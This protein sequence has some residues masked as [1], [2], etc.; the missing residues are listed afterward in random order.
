MHTAKSSVLLVAMPYA[1]VTIPS[2]QLPVLEAYCRQHGIDV[3]TRHLY[4]KA[5]EIYGL[6]NYHSL[7]H[8]PGD[9]YT[10][11]VAFSQYLFPDHWEKN[12]EKI[13]EHYSTHISA[14]AFSFEDYLRLTDDF[15]HWTLDH[16]YWQ[17]FDLI[18][19]TLNYGQL[20]PS[21][22]IAKHIKQHNPEKKIVLGGSRVVGD[23]G[24]G[25]LRAF[26]YI[27][28]VVSGDG[29]DPLVRLASDPE[30]IASIP[31]LIY[32]E[33]DNVRWNAAEPN[34]DFTT[35][36]LPSYDPF[37][38]T[39][40][41][42]SSELQQFYHYHGRLPVEISR[43]CWW[44]RCTFCNLNIQHPCYRE[45]PIDH[46]TSEIQQFS[47]RYHVLDFQLIGNTLP[48]T[49][50]R[51]L[52]DALEHLSKDFSFFVEARAGQLTSDDYRR[53]KDAGFTT[54]QTGIESFSRH[55]LRTMNKGVRVIDNIAALKFCRQYDIRNSYNLIIHYPNEAPMDF[56]ETHHV[57]QQLQ[58]YLEPPQLCPLRIMHGSPIQQHP[59]T[60]NI[61]SLQPAPIDVLI[62]PPT[63]LEKNF[64]FVYAFTTTNPV[65]DHDW[66]T[67]V[68]NWKK[69]RESAEAEAVKTHAA[70]DRL[71]FYSVDGGTFMKI[72]D[73][74]DP[75]RIRILELNTLER[76]V[77]LACTDIT[78]YHTLRDQFA[79]VPD[80]E[81][82]TIL[83]SFE[84]A[85][86]IYHEDD[87]YLSLP[88]QYHSTMPQETRFQESPTPQ[89]L[90]NP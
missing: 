82:D 24:C 22:A 78:S 60:Y 64:T 23:L 45:K 80:F 39:L 33:Q 28:Y 88:L 86:L 13:K 52:F 31:G 14:P 54:I 46:I 75:Q 42:C 10:A 7:I 27:D 30:D 51:D 3:Q 65:P 16:L 21:L 57:V 77:L 73:K 38:D 36:P 61:S 55:Y 67:L 79:F 48:R 19:F 69:T 47:D 83:Q 18:G 58:G 87:D 74:R 35:A 41:T 4:L 32:R 76:S 66:G 34:I 71:V 70:I 20:L 90:V 59:G 56:E 68:E 11:Q 37:F 2:I 15:Y 5:A 44:N 43:G 50:Y 62:Y 72:Y 81:L 1:G 63:V 85:G 8:P 12:L 49:R 9:S 17:S 89:V 53:M 25:I 84:H 26:N 40:R 6:T 29:E